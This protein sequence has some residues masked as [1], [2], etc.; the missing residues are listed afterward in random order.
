MT[1]AKFYIILEKYLKGVAN[2]NE[3]N[4]IETFYSAL[5]NEKSANFE[6]LDKEGNTIKHTLK[7]QIDKS[8]NQEKKRFNTRLIYKVAASIVLLLSVALTYVAVSTTA[9]PNV[10]Y[11]EIS[12]HDGIRKKIELPDGTLIEIN[13]NSTLKYPKTFG[14]T[15]ERKVFLNGEAFFNVSKNKAKPFVVMANGLTT[16][17][18]GT[19]FNVNSNPN[20]VN[21]YLV[22]GSVEVATNE[23]KQILK[24]KQKAVYI[25][26]EKGIGITTPNQYK[27]L[28][29]RA[30]TFNFNNET[31]GEVT[32][33]L[34]KRFNVTIQFS[35][36]HIREKRLSAHFEN[37]NLKTIL[38]SL[39]K[40]GNLN[41]KINNKTK[42]ILIYE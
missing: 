42:K 9:K 37:Q 7:K 14:T 36:G 25:P 24:P 21:V 8:I 35:N 19:Q 18:L 41:F 17:V 6:W 33:L 20:S 28:A 27:E 34:E 10:I 29:W 15:K 22:E 5:Q 23:E 2:K 3:A 30:N 4:I 16:K 31:L 13:I 12:T 38:M 32:K 26:T 1:K 40:G 11:T 39:T